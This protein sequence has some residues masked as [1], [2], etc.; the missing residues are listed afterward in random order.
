MELEGD[1]YEEPA[2]PG[3]GPGYCAA[4]LA[5]FGLSVLAFFL[6]VWWIVT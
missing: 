4:A 3:S 5:G 6:F 1:E 2:E